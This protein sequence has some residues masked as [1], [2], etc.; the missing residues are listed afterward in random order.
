M[1]YRRIG[2]IIERYK[3]KKWSLKQ[4]CTSIEKAKKA[5]KLLAGL[6]SGLI[7]KEDVGKGRFKK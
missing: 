5:L 2:N 4:T 6:E 1:P 3:N 7:K